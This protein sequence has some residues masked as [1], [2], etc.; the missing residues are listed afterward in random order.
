[1]VTVRLIAYPAN[2]YEFQRRAQELAARADTPEQLQQA[3]RRQYSRARVVA[4]VTDIVERWYAYR[5][6]RWMNSRDNS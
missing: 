4:G 3:L 2:D 1:M 5:D 6:G